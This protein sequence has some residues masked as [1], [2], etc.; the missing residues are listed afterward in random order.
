MN[1]FSAY[2]PKIG[3]RFHFEALVNSPVA[4]DNIYQA[5]VS[6]SPPANP[7]LKPPKTEKAF[8]LTE[9]DWTNSWPYYFSFDEDEIIM[10]NQ[11]LL[12]N[13]ALIIDLKKY[14]FKRK[15]MA[16]FGFAILPL[17]QEF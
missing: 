3:F 12:K 14:N 10:R 6:L 11:P 16:H 1:H 5:M 4:G 9:I 15:E 2:E 8:T 13:S 7:Y 17:V